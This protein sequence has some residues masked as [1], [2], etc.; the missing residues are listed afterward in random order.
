MSYIPPWWSPSKF[1]C[2]DQCPQLFYERYVLH[3]KEAPSEAMQFGSA[4]HKGLEAHFNGTDGELAFRREWRLRSL[5]L[6]QVDPKL[7]KTGLDLISRVMDLGLDGIPERKVWVRTDDYLNAPLLGYVDLWCSVSNTIVDFK[8]TVGAW[9]AERA[10][11]EMHQPCFYSW[12]YWQETGIMPG[13]EYIVLNRATGSLSRFKT[14]RTGDQISAWLDRCREIAV[15]V[16]ADQF[17]CKC[18]T[19]VSCPECG[20]TWEH[21]HQCFPNQSKRIRLGGKAA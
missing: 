18:R 15:A 20:A 8:T 11:K 6:G 17:A 10:E 21:G 19:G 2:Y 4:V 12:A 13:F 7:S 14:E 9:S 3:A 5:E 1:T 16:A